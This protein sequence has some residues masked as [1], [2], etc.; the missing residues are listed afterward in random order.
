MIKENLPPG[1]K[2]MSGMTDQRTK[3]RENPHQ[4]HNIPEGW[5]IKRNPILP[6]DT[7][8][9]IGDTEIHHSEDMNLPEGW[10][11]KIETL[12]IGEM[13]GMADIIIEIGLKGDQDQDQEGVQEATD[14]DPIPKGWKT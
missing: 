10:M 11:D 4:D 3:V 2:E 1:W 12:M 7:V 6:K 13:T 9:M 14:Q 5:M 8:L